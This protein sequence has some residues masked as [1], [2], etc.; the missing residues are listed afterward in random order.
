MHHESV[1]A[2]SSI[3]GEIAAQLEVLC[4]GLSSVHRQWGRN[5][6]TNTGC[7]SSRLSEDDSCK[8]MTGCHVQLQMVRCGSSYTADRAPLTRRYDGGS[9]GLWCG[10]NA[11]LWKTSGCTASWPL[12]HAAVPDNYRRISQ[13][14]HFAVEMYL[15]TVSN[16]RLIISV[17]GWYKSIHFWR[18]YDQKTIFTF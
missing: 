18:I 16:V 17:F 15:T 3:A 10:T 2:K 11:I 12:R 13:K 6:W 14:K 1:A 4:N 8:Y 5:Q 7:S 9:F